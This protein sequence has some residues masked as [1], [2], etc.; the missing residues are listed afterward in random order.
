MLSSL[1]GICVL[2]VRNLKYRLRMIHFGIFL[3]KTLF[4]NFETSLSFAMV[5]GFYG[6]LFFLLCQKNV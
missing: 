6:S 1:E 4:I 5:E 2:R 3:L